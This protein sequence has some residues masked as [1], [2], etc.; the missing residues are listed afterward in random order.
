MV[1]QDDVKIVRSLAGEV[2][3]VAALDIQEEKRELW[4]RLNALDP[5]RPMV[6]ID[7]ICWNEMKAGELALQCRDPE[8]RAYEEQFRQTL[9][10]WRNFPVDMVVESF[11]EVPKAVT[12]T[13]YGIHI[14]E[15]LVVSDPTNAVVGHLYTNQLQKEEDLEKIQTPKIGHDEAE[16]ARRLAVAH[17]LFDG[18]LEVRPQ[19]YDP[20]YLSLWDPLSMWMGVENALYALIDTPD[21]VHRILERMTAGA[22]DRLDQLET[23]GL[24]CQPQSDV[25]CTGAYTD[26]L[27][28]MG[29][30]PD[31]PRTRDLWMFSMAQMVSTVSPAT[32]R[33]FE[34]AYIQRIASRFGL[35]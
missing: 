11:V 25:H 24:L 22:L 30:D 9:Y 32:F 19:G 10:K 28:A 34:V 4:R 27:P 14:E 16:T 1:N 29:Y 26:G 15:Q 20:Q 5:V 35:V 3:A 31:R 18:I 33:E 7:Q 6:I 12:D 21:F 23:Q 17:E 8:C 2:A 13:G